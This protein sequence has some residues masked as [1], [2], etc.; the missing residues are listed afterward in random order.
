[1][2]F[3][4]GFLLHFSFHVVQLHRHKQLWLSQKI[5]LAAP[6][7]LTKPHSRRDIFLS[8]LVLLEHA[9]HRENCMASLTLY[10]PI[11]RINR[12]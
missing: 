9:R 2:P 10:D 5:F 3:P 8:F 1:M 4:L 11:L 12:A 7:A 6:G